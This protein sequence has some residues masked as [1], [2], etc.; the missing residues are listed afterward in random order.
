M[1]KHGPLHITL[2]LP[3]M[4][5]LSSAL[6]LLASI[7]TGRAQ[8]VVPRFAISV[9]P[10]TGFSMVKPGTS[11][12]HSVTLHNKSTQPITVV[13]RIVDFVSDGKTGTPILKETTTFPY[14]ANT[15]EALAPL[16][17]PAGKQVAVPFVIKAPVDALQQEFHLTILFEN[18]TLTAETTSSTLV[19]TIGSN[20]VVFVSG[21]PARPKL[22]VT[23]LGRS[24][25][26]DSFRPL[27]FK[28]LVKNQGN[29]ATVA[30]GSA[31]I[32]NWRGRTM[33][34]IP[35][36]PD[37]VLAGSTRELRGAQPAAPI[38]PTDPKAAIAT[39]L[40]PI[41]FSHKEP[42]IL[43]AYTVE[44]DLTTVADSGTTLSVH[45][46]TI[47]A[48]PISLLVLTLATVSVFVFIRIILRKKTTNIALN[49]SKNVKSASQ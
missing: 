1:Q 37:I 12:I 13:P 38:L 17:V 2:K 21:E 25:V 16:T 44:I 32:K 15:S 10:A 8:Q 34:T 4:A 28:P 47:I 49:T 14:L 6:L 29:A 30:S 33:A 40:E 11:T 41:P 23:T 7:S 26:V 19:P 48:M 31:V 42:I 9:S 3:L 45:N 5:L 36:Y 24:K 35:I 43:G 18:Q 46:F 22:K 39:Q 27:T 20:L